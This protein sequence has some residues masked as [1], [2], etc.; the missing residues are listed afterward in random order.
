MKK[1]KILL[2]LDYGEPLIGC[3]T[4][5]DGRMICEVI[6][7][8]TTEKSLI[9][10]TDREKI[11]IEHEIDD[12]HIEKFKFF[13]EAQDVEFTDFTCAKENGILRVT[14]E[15]ITTNNAGPK[16]WSL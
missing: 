6:V 5:D 15:V 13:L 8:G 7:P 2:R 14:A 9:V 12:T 16:T 11:M 1:S 4:I 3:L 10:V